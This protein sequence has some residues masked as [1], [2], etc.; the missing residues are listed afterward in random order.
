[1]RAHSEGLDRD[2]SRARKPIRVLVSEGSS[3][4]AR[5]AITALG[6]AG[7]HVEVCDPNGL[8]LA[9]F[10]RFVKRLHRCP[11]FASDPVG[12]YRFVRDLLK[13]GPFQVL[14]PAHEQAFLF[15]RQREALSGLVGVPVPT[16]DA[17]E[18]VQGKVA[19]VATFAALEIPTPPS[20]IV[21]DQAELPSAVARV[22]LPCYVKADIGTASGGVWRVT[23]ETSFGDALRGLISQ[24]AFEA[25]VVVQAHAP[26][27][28]E[29]AYA[30][31]DHGR[32]IAVHTVRQLLAGPRGGDIQKV[33][34]DRPGVRAHVAQLAD[35]LGWHG[36]MTL[37]YLHDEA[38][39]TARFIE[40]NPRLAEPGNAVLSGLDLPMLLV[41][42]ALGERL[43]EQPLG[44]IG[45]RTHMA[46]QAIVMAAAGGA[47]RSE[48]LRT[49][50]ALIQ[51]TGRFRDSRESLTPTRIDPLSVIPA[52]GAVAI[53]LFIRPTAWEWLAAKQVSSYALTQPAA[54][55]IREMPVLSLP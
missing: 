5:E 29:R 24:N 40:V 43:D 54:Q 55:A 14:Y 20:E 30:I 47:S 17:I 49:I 13:A 41:R 26:G 28:F 11:H 23:D 25:G 3:L 33:S 15:A 19:T 22:G 4:S 10:S 45:V 50:A 1:M 53:A 48:I 36:A 38:G 51:K 18:K 32:L 46:I 2:A 35:G 52:A 27:A 34:V 21:H 8:C 44:R 37:D 31:A 39:N 6:T 12:Y 42:L 9:R 7:C 16:F